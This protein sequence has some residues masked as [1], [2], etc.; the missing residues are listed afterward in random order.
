MCLLSLGPEFRWCEVGGGRHNESCRQ[1]MTRLVSTVLIKQ[2]ASA[3][4]DVNP[5]RLVKGKMA[6]NGG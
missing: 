4:A 5:H 6:L 3:E 2:L 1:R